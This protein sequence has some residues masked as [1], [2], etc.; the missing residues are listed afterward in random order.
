MR[1]CA[2]NAA[3]TAVVLACVS[4]AQAGV[5]FDTVTVGDPGNPGEWSGESYGGY[6]PDRICGAVDYVYNLGRYEV[7]AGQYTDF[8]NAVA[9]TDTYGLYS[10]SMWD[11]TCGCKIQRDGSPGGYTYSV[12]GDWADR[13]VN[14][15]SFWD[16]ARF[17]NWMHNGQPAGPQGPATTEHGAYTLDG[18]TG[19]DGSWITRNPGATWCIPSEDEWYKAAYYDGDASVY[20][21][22]PTGTDA[23]PSN[24]L[25]DPDPGNNAN[26]DQDGFTIGHPYYRTEVGEFE[27]SASPSGTFD[28]GGNVWEWHETVLHTSHRGARGG[29]WYTDDS[30]LLAARRGAS[31]PTTESIFN[32]FRVAYVPEPATIS[33]LACSLALGS[34]VRLKRHRGRRV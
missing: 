12:A 16:A 31:F 15:A 4:S 2:M 20:Y 27:R 18:Y 1:E 23:V 29:A 13:P 9:D 26:F 11:N 22:Y 32:G 14:M 10:T 30:R 21:D 24:D 5:V 28:Q 7:T 33:V 6:G 3:L 19:T 25:E 17:A 34:I 8:L